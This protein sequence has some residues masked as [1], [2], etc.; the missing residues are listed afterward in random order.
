MATFTQISHE[1]EIPS[2]RRAPLRGAA[3]GHCGG[4]SF[5]GG[6]VRLAHW[7]GR[8]GVEPHGGVV[9]DHRGRG[10]RLHGH[11]HRRQR[12]GQQHGPGRGFGRHDHGVGDRRRG[13]VRGP[14]RHRRRR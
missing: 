6:L 7:R 8:R 4:L 3:T 1:E 9:A 10:R 13:G 14:G 5:A 2:L 11:E 12:R